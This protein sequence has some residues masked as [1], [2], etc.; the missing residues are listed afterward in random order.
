[1]HPVNWARFPEYDIGVALVQT[2]ADH[3]HENRWYLYARRFNEADVASQMVLAQ[4][5]I[6]S[7]VGTTQTITSDATWTNNVN[8]SVECIGGGA[9]GARG[10]S[11]STSG[12]GGG[13]GAYSKIVNVTITTPGTTQYYVQVGKGGTWNTTAPDPAGDSWWTLTSPGTSFPSSGTA[14]GA[15]AGATLAALTTTTGGAGGGAGSAYASPATN[16]V[17]ATGGS[18]GTAGAS[19]T[20]GGGGGGAAGTNSSA[21]AGTGP[22][23]GTAGN[24][25]TGGG[26]TG[27][28][29][30]SPGGVGGN[31]TNIDG[32]RGS[33]GGGGGGNAGPSTGGNG[34]LYGGGGGGGGR[35]NGAGGSGA[36]GIV[37]L[38]WTP[39]ESISV[40]QAAITATG[41]T[42]GGLDLNVVDK[43]SVAATGKTITVADNVEWAGY[44]LRQTVDNSMVISGPLVSG[45]NSVVVAFATAAGTSGTLDAAYIGDA[46]ASGDAYDFASTPVR[47]QVSGSN[48]RTLTGAESFNFDSATIS[49]TIGRDLLFSASFSGTSVR[50]RENEMIAAVKA[51][52]AA[53]GKTVTVGDTT[54]SSFDS[55]TNAWIAAVGSSNIS[56]G[57]QTVVDNLIVGLKADG[58]WSKLDRL[59]LFAAENTASALVDLKATA[60]AT[61]VNS[62]T[63]S[64][65]GYTFNGSTNYINTGYNPASGTNYAQNSAHI[66]VWPV[67]ISSSAW[68]QHGNYDNTKGAGLEW[69][70]T[71]WYAYINDNT[72]SNTSVTKGSTG[73]ITLTRP[74]SG[75]RKLYVSGT[76]AYSDSVSSTGISSNN[77]YVGAGNAAGSATH[78]TTNKIATFSIGGSLTDTD[79]ANLYSR[80]R[81]YMTAVEPTLSLFKFEGTDGSTTFTEDVGGHTLG[82]IGAPEIDTAQFK[83]GASSC[84]FNAANQAITYNAPPDLDF[85]TRDFTIDFWVRFPSASMG[86]QVG[87]WRAF[88]DIGSTFSWLISK[89]VGDNIVVNRSDVGNDLYTSASS[90]AA[91]TWYHVALTRSSGTARLFLNGTL[92]VSG[93]SDWSSLSLANNYSYPMIGSYATTAYLCWIDAFRI[94]GKALWTANFTPPVSTDYP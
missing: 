66:S 90:I 48:T 34:G 65:T 27:G 49:H 59:W 29:A 41:K 82:A 38:T 42:V 76:S 13:G 6:T 31:G 16:S 60:T 71:V 67:N 64:T 3:G 46:A 94:S 17:K 44:T 45:S 70:S 80:L 7:N 84:Y 85:G 74:A 1:M 47:L 54:G 51:A 11:T 39:P 87:L 52:I 18:G 22:S 73:L 93:S 28:S 40:T 32:T 36:Q 81:T 5:V 89:D 23:A 37:V 9:H 4:T 2:R 69:G 33:G 91:D 72:L 25:A 30:G 78:H 75:S 15:K 53:A 26:G 79:V 62:P 43:A 56:S 12:A 21:S 92:S 14:V 88:T 8:N 35:S 50:L 10:A 83:F 20:A 57:R 68:A 55:A 58:V 24:N 63:F 86:S 19:A 61:A 77:Y